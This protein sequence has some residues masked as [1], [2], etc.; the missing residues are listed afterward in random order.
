M[1]SHINLETATFAG[2]CFWCTA[3]D[4][5]KCKGVHNVISGYTG[6]HQKNPTYQDVAT[7]RSGH[8]EAVQIHFDP[9]KT[10]YAQLLDIFWKHI[11]PTDP[12]GQFVDRGA[13]YRTAIFYHD[14]RQKQLAEK[15][16]QA[17]S[18]SGN[19]GKPIVTEILAASQFYPAEKHHQN[20]YKQNPVHYKFY[21][22][23]SGRDQFLSKIW[24][25]NKHNPN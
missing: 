4:F 14:D 15:S 6:G 10:S 13:Q 24:I 11:D 3:S 9:I 17:L 20:Y 23:N 5:E 21:R 1:N 16:K 7:G 19:F 12:G 25:R 2:G 22:Q 18:H 8:W